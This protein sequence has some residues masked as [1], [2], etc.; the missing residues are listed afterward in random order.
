MLIADTLKSIEQRDE[1]DRAGG[2]FLLEHIFHASE[3]GTASHE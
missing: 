2:A 3:V 1:C